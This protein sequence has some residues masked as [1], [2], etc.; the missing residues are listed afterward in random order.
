M[1][2]T[3]I[4]SAVSASLLLS[5]THHAI[6]T[7]AVPDEEQQDISSFYDAI[8]ITANTHATA[9]YEW[10]AI[11]VY[12]KASNLLDEEYLEYNR[13]E[14]IIIGQPRQVNLSVRGNF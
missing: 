5:V 2:F 8:T 13:E 7:E 3:R 9:G 10:E 14:N 4:A 6:A 12:L 11:G 1:E